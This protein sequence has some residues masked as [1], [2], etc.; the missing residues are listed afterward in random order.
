MLLSSILFSKAQQ[1]KE[2][3]KLINFRACGCVGDPQSRVL[4]R[5]PA[6]QNKSKHPRIFTHTYSL[7]QVH[8]VSTMC[9]FRKVSAELFLL[10][11]EYMALAEV[12]SFRL[13]ARPVS[14]AVNILQF[15]S[16]FCDIFPEVRKL[17]N[18]FAVA[19]ISARHPNS[20]E[21]HLCEVDSTTEKQNLR[22]YINLAVT[23]R[24]ITMLEWCLSSLSNC[25]IA[26][27]NDDHQH[28][29]YDLQYALRVTL[30]TAADLAGSVDWSLGADAILRTLTSGWAIEDR[31]YV[32]N[33][34]LT[35]H[36]MRWLGSA[37]CK[38]VDTGKGRAGF[39]LMCEVFRSCSMRWQGGS[40]K[41]LFQELAKCTEKNLPAD[42]LHVLHERHSRFNL[43]VLSGVNDYQP[44]FSWII[45]KDD[46]SLAQQVL[47]IFPKWSRDH[48]KTSYVLFALANYAAERGFFDVAT[49][50]TSQ[51]AAFWPTEYLPHLQTEFRAIPVDTALRALDFDP[52]NS[53]KQVC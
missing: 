2:I 44:Y 17:G 3:R 8:N 21:E 34:S 42:A 47:S 52:T 26:L 43:G 4:G 37:V 7:T 22:S 6:H 30:E 28:Y 48:P 49:H 20:W 1:R 38:L 25:T 15:L 29:D 36:R 18:E 5:S 51:L 40:M 11:S 24:D 46:N 16:R 19:V 33:L 14:A 13:V 10:M 35:A 45:W 23:N 9:A 53:V 41:S 50:A 12:Q 32:G 27:M 31:G 39:H